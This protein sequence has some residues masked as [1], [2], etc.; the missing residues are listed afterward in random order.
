[1][2]FQP[3][4]Q[5]KNLTRVMFRGLLWGFCVGLAAVKLCTIFANVDSSVVPQSGILVIDP[6]KI[7][8]LQK[9]YFLPIGHACGNG[10]VT[11]YMAYDG[12]RI[13]KSCTPFASP[14]KAEK[15]LQNVLGDTARI[16]ES[17][18]IKQG[19][20][21]RADKRVVAILAGMDQEIAVIVWTKDSALFII[22]SPSLESALEFERSDVE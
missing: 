1:M 13:S 18:S 4:I 10:Y 6:V 15:A 11:A 12:S 17:T 21:R 2:P 20:G 19:R 7:A 22:D 3:I 14:F 9:G 5:H 16:I 8:G